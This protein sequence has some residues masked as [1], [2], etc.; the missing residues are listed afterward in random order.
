MKFARL[1]GFAGAFLLTVVGFSA[2]ASGS[3]AQLTVH[4]VFS[5]GPLADSNPC[6]RGLGWSSNSGKFVEHY[7]ANAA[8]G[9]AFTA[10]FVG[11][12]TF[13]GD[14]PMDSATGRVTGWFGGTMSHGGLTQGGGTFSVTVVDGW[15]NH[16]SASGVA[17]G[18]IGVDGTVHVSFLRLR[19]HCN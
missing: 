11:T 18:T 4:G 12:F 3:A 15:G 19:V 14:N 9:L 1:A 6:T 7:T 8:G 17:H 16:I 5:L 13:T 10:T 2:P